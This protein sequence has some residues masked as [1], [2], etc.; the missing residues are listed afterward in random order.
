MKSISGP[1]ASTQSSLEPSSDGTILDHNQKT[2]CQDPY[3]KVEHFP[4][5]RVS[6]PHHRMMKGYCLVTNRED[7][8]DLNM[9]W[10][11]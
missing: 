9:K 10:Q 11:K 8:T 7:E 2:R 6:E 3:E 1:A 4:L 5:S